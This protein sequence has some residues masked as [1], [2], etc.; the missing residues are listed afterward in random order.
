MSIIQL[1]VEPPPRFNRY[2]YTVGPRFNFLCSGERGLPGIL[3]SKY[4]DSLVKSYVIHLQFFSVATT[5]TVNTIDLT[6]TTTLPIPVAK[7][8]STGVAI[9]T[10]VIASNAATESPVVG[11]V[12]TEQVDPPT[13]G[14]E[15][16]GEKGE[17]REAGSSKCPTYKEQYDKMS[18]NYRLRSSLPSNTEI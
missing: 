2:Y 13:Q 14:V 9:E 7:P 8:V 6:T 15:E 11:V 3:G 18:K 5:E 1:G 4:R 16:E 10:P 12:A 17:K